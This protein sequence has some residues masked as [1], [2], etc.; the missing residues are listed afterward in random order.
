MSAG[1]TRT[2]R[3]RTI[4]LRS[5]G[6]TIRADAHG[7]DG[8]KPAEDS[9]RLIADGD[10]LRLNLGSVKGQGEVLLDV[11]VNRAGIEGERQRTAGLAK[12]QMRWTENADLAPF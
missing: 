8:V 9:S 11:H 3:T 1:R 12:R 5:A 4:N 6:V 7:A 2:W 10:G